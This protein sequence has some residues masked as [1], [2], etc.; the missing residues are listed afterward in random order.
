MMLNYVKESSRGKGTVIFT[1]DDSDKTVERHS[2][3]CCHC[4]HTF[5]IKPGSKKER[6]YCAWC[7]GPTCGEESCDTRMGTN[8]DVVGCQP[9][10]QRLEAYESRFRNF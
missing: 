6:G 9:F 7:D 10:E 3:T 4:N 8:G 2:I 5:I 1:P